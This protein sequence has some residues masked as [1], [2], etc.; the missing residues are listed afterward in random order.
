MINMIRISAAVI[1]IVGAGL[2]HGSWTNRWGPSPALAAL[3]ARF[4]S[5]PMDIGD[6]KGTT[7]EL[8][9]PRAS[10]GRR[11]G[12]PR[13]AVH[14]PES[15]GF[16]LGA[17]A[18]R[19]SRKNFH[20]YPRHLLP[21]CGLSPELPRSHPV[22]LRRPTNAAA[23]F[24]TAVAT[25]GGTNPSILRIFWGWNASKGWPAPENPRWSFAS[26]PALCKLYVIRE[27]AGVVVDPG[28]DPCNDFMSVFLPELDELVFSARR[29]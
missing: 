18:R 24:Q 10:D 26:A 3:A 5:V 13:S 19:S 9:A 22:P 20:A 1:L 15:R 4:E 16:R 11:G 8:S 27:T 7:F 23:E 29:Q 12:L 25:R 17:V 14:E 2:V 28:S 6:W 21:G